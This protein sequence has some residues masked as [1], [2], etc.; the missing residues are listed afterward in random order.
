MNLPAYQV[1]NLGVG[2]RRHVLPAAGCPCRSNCPATRAAAVPRSNGADAGRPPQCRE[3]LRLGSSQPEGH[4]RHSCF[5]QPSPTGF[6]RSKCGPGG[7]PP[8]SCLHPTRGH[9]CCV[10]ACPRARPTHFSSTA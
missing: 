5:S 7:A 2:H 10:S 3:R 6:G 8:S 4:K 1:W 9:P